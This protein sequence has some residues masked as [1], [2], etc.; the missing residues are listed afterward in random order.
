[1]SIENKMYAVSQIDA[2]ELENQLLNGKPLR[3]LDLSH[4]IG[5]SALQRFL[6]ANERH[7]QEEFVHVIKPDAG[8]PADDIRDH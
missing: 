7:F 3:Q 6:G 1:M 2:L 5:D 4:F 8:V